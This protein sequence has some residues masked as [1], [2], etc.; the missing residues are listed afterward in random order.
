[1]ATQSQTGA[2]QV[3][4]VAVDLVGRVIQGVR[5]KGLMDGI[6]QSRLPMTFGLVDVAANLPQGT[7]GGN[8]TEEGVVKSLVVTD[9]IVIHK[10][11]CTYTQTPSHK[12]NGKSIQNRGKHAHAHNK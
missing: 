12:P 1:M 6:G 5:H 2:P 11:S 3:L 9:N 8:D 10:M 7:L 4:T